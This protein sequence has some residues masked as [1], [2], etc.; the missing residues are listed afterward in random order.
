MTT[1]ISMFGEALLPLWGRSRRKGRKRRQEW[2][3]T[4]PNAVTS[5]G[6]T[7]GGGRGTMRSCNE[8]GVEA[9]GNATTNQTRGVRQKV[10][11]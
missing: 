10:E 7:S 11:V 2:R 1:E 8:M 9:L 6:A 3:Q 5:K 4:T